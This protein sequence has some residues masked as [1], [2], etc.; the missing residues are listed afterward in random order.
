MGED[1]EVD[2][3]QTV[4]ED[5]CESMEESETV[6]NTSK[7]TQTLTTMNYVQYL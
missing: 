1:E 7:T 2:S 3:I 4:D 5:V 6:V